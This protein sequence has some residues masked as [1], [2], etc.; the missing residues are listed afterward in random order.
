[1]FC[2]RKP[3]EIPDKIPL[4]TAT[5]LTA[6][7]QE[8]RKIIWHNWYEHINY[9]LWFH[10]KYQF[11][12]KP[13]VGWTNNIIYVFLFFF[14]FHQ[15][16]KK[17]IEEKLLLSLERVFF[18]NFPKKKVI[19]KT[20]ATCNFHHA[21]VAAIFY[22]LIL[23]C[24]FRM[25]NEYKKYV[26]AVHTGEIFP[27]FCTFSTVFFFKHIKKYVAQSIIFYSDCSFMY[28]R[29]IETWLFYCWTNMSVFASEYGES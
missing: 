11:C 22:C 1:M 9:I 5:K 4:K 14:I 2:P 8:K 18:V 6:T 25:W 16:K 24:H 27:L 10:I 13:I 29:I 21:V 3:F 23:M 15:P 28:E 17:I 26:Y 19:Y 12:V 7:V 20:W